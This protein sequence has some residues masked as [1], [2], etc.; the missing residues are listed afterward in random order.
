MQAKLQEAED[1]AAELAAKLDIALDEKRQLEQRIEEFTHTL[2]ERD[3]LI[4]QLR[5][6]KQVHPPSH[7]CNDLSVIGLGPR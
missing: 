2:V 4:A 6:G 7:L 1:G 5:A 3:E